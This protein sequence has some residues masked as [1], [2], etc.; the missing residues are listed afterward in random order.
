MYSSYAVISRCLHPMLLLSSIAYGN[1]FG[2]TR[3]DGSVQ[4]ESE[5]NAMQPRI[6][7]YKGRFKL[8]PRQCACGC[9]R[10]AVDARWQING[11]I[12]SERCYAR[13]RLLD[14]HYEQWIPAKVQQL[15]MWEEVEG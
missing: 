5:M 2:N 1:S 15:E 11:H 7:I 14:A 6:I 3:K 10:R 4:N 12:Y 13:V 9:Q 8:S